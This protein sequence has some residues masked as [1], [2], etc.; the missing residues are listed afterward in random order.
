MIYTILEIVVTFSLGYIFG[1]MLTIL[2]DEEH[3]FILGGPAFLCVFLLTWPLELDR[4]GGWAEA[5]LGAY[6]IDIYRDHIEWAVIGF[7][8]FVLEQFACMYL[9]HQEEHDG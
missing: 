5:S 1:C 2:D 8:A 6:S 3:S 4:A 7:I 9:D